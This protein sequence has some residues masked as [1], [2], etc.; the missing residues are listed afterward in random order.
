M[1]EIMLGKILSI[2]EI[3]NEGYNRDPEEINRTKTIASEKYPDMD[4]YLIKTDKHS[5]YVLIGNG[6]CCCES[7]GYCS[8]E[9]DFSKFIGK[10]LKE[11]YL[12]DI[13]CKTLEC[14]KNKEDE[15][16]CFYDNIQFVNF[17]TDENDLLQ[18]SVYNSHNGW[19]GHSIRI[20]KDDEPILESCL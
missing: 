11:V 19:Y 8:S 20:M 6:Q 16:L 3:V 2:E 14:R 10:N 15:D 4:G 7:W 18:L 9:D 5:F 12:T 13:D 17:V 1:S